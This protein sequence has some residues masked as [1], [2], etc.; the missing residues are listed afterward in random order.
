MGLIVWHLYAW[1]NCIK[2]NKKAW[3][4]LQ[5]NGRFNFNYTRPIFST[6]IVQFPNVMEL[7]HWLTHPPPQTTQHMHCPAFININ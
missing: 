4:W 6:Q 2:V 5:W 1:L 7:F 3:N